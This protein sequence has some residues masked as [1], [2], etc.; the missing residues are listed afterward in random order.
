VYKVRARPFSV[1]SP[2][3][4]NMDFENSSCDYT[5]SLVWKAGNATANLQFAVHVDKPADGTNVMT[6]SEP[7]DKEDKRSPDEILK[8]AS[9]GFSVHLEKNH[10]LIIRCPVGTLMT[11]VRA[12]SQ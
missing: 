11:D 1:A 7:T 8:E 5:L 9:R 3:T 12:S 2:A 4:I 10:D 6:T